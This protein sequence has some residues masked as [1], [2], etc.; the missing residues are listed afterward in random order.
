MPALGKKFSCWSCWWTE[1]Q[2]LLSTLPKIPLRWEAKLLLISGTQCQTFTYK[3]KKIIML[4]AYL[5]TDQRKLLLFFC[6]MVPK[7]ASEGSQGVIRKI[8]GWQSG[9]FT[10]EGWLTWLKSW[11]CRGYCLG[12]ESSYSACYL[13]LSQPIKPN[14]FRSLPIVICYL[15]GEKVDLAALKWQSRNWSNFL[16]GIR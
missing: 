2:E 3:K 4:M 9:T 5:K 11:G 15:C 13:K 8:S 6:H 10:C 16:A 12:S 14:V 7:T 1:A